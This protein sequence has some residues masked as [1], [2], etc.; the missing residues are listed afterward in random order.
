MQMNIIIN[1][2]FLH[3]IFLFMIDNLQSNLYS[4]F[5]ELKTNFGN[6]LTPLLIN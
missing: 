3:G 4:T 2:E 5:N 1:G 6:D